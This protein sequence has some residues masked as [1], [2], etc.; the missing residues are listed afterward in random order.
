MEQSYSRPTYAAVIDKFRCKVDDMES[1]L[2]PVAPLMRSRRPGPRKLTFVVR[3]FYLRHHPKFFTDTNTLK[4][5][6]GKNIKTERK[7]A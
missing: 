4:F 6:D 7:Q 3:K 1:T 5:K 2:L